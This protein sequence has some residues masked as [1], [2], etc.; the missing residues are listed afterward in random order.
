[1]LDP[2]IAICHRNLPVHRGKR[3]VVTSLLEK[4]GY[5]VTQ[6]E[7]GSLDL[8]T[9]GVVWILGNANWFP[10]VC[11]Q[12]T[13]TPRPK[14]PFVIIW[15]TEP[16][17]LSEAAGLP[18]PRLH[19]REI[20]K[21]LLRDPRATDVYTN[22]LRLHRLAQQG[23]PN[24]LVVSTLGRREFLT[25]RGIAAHWVPFG[26][27]PSSH[28][29]DMSLPRDIYVLFL[30]ALEIP[31]RKR[32]I[33][34]LGQRGVNLLA[35]GSWS[36]P[37]YWGE[38]RIRLLN[39]TKIL[40]NISRHPGNLADSRLILGMANKA[41]VIS[42]PMYNPA[43]YVPG[44]HYV[45]V[46][47]EEMPETIRYYLAHDDERERIVNEGHWLVTQQVTMAQSVSRILELIRECIN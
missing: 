9:N 14:R 30:G 31:R 19:L 42:E 8:V 7:D 23:L 46:T 3:Y 17:P 47:V 44:K 20:L 32:A 40:L 41:L 18:W 33:K 35:Q 38:N 43:P 6:V 36:D 45:S 1:M 28:G 22:Y 25:E 34:Y 13:S 16:L 27:D 21:I 29:R 24:L 10:T 39:R 2:A 4:A 15:H 12:L 5:Q 37:A 26:Y 11:R